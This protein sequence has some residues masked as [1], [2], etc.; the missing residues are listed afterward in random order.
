MPGESRLHGDVVEAVEIVDQ[1]ETG[2]L[3]DHADMRGAQPDRCRV[4]QLGDVVAEQPH[5]PGAGADLRRHG[6]DQRRF[7]RAPLGPRTTI[8]SPGSTRKLRPRSAAT[9]W[10]RPR[11]N[12]NASSM[13]ITGSSAEA[14]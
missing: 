8:R 1:V 6:G 3:A 9:S 11:C 12:T 13:S 7:A 2:T 4:I 10:V 14:K 5:P